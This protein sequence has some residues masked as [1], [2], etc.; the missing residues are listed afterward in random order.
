MTTS[1][2]F[3]A[4]PSALPASVLQKASKAVVEYEPETNLSILEISHRSN[5]F[6]TIINKTIDDLKSLLNIPSNYKVLFLQ[7]GGSGQFSAVAL[8]LLANRGKNRPV[9]YIVTGG[10]SAKAAE[11]ATNL[12]ANVN[13]AVNS[14]KV[15][16]S[17]VGIP[18]QED[19]SLSGKDAAYVYYCANETVYGVEFD[20]IPEVH[21]DVPLVCDMSSNI[22]SRPFDVSKFGLIFA[23]AQKNIGPSG[24]TIV[25]IREDLLSHLPDKTE[26]N[27]IPIVLDYS[28]M[29][30]NNSLYN[31][32]P[33]Y[34]I[35]VTGLMLQ[36]IT[37]NGGASGMDALAERKSNLLYTYLE[38]SNFYKCPVNAGCRSCMNIVF[39]LNTEALEE[40]FIKKAAND[41]RFYQLKGHRSVG[42]IRVSCYNAV[43]VEGVEKLLKFMD[44]FAKEHAN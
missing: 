25:I 14:K 4:G 20:Y 31:T 33:V 3:G 8:N 40:E 6:K 38:N 42:G 30:E 36:W 13:I 39:R 5:T 22:L 19:W 27:P 28:V 26:F 1:Y 15:Y 11:E 44:E 17:Y 18:K 21:P 24:V 34:S 9:D 16:G 7:G 41:H 2:N 35:F 12:G 23:G 43:P 10:W 32:P 29:A 37:E